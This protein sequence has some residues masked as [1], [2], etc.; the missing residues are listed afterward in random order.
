MGLTCMHAIGTALVAWHDSPCMQPAHQGYMRH[1]ETV[2]LYGVSL[3][4]LPYAW[5]ACKKKCVH[6]LAAPAAYP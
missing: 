5:D 2:T 1:D 4:R 6:G 3:C